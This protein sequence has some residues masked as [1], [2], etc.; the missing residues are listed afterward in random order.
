MKFTSKQILS[1]GLLFSVSLASSALIMHLGLTSSA[2]GLIP[3]IIAA[4]A[5]GFLSG[6]MVN[7]IIGDKN[8]PHPIS[9]HILLAGTITASLPVVFIVC[10][11]N[12]HDEFP[13][14]SFLNKLLGQY[15]DRISPL[16]K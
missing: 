4:L 16:H 15:H 2:F 13:S 6:C 8:S 5:G 14:H 10:T 11:F 12:L 9:W 1:I 3:V 7:S